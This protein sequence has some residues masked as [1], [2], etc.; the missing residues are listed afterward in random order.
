MSVLAKAAQVI[1]VLNR[2]LGP[3]R[4]GVIA[5]EVG[6]PKSSAHRLLAEMASLGMVRKLEDGNYTA[7]YRLVQW[8]H[9]ADRALGIRQAAEPVMRRL[10]E[11][12]AESVHLH[13]PEGSHRVCAAGAPGP[14]TLRPV[15][16]L[17]QVLP[18]GSGA[19]GRLLLAFADERVRAEARQQATDVDEASWPDEAELAMLRERGW[20]TTTG[21]LEEGLTA[22]SAVVK[23]RTGHALGALTI[24]GA[25]GRLND[26]RCSEVR[27]LLVAAAMD[28]A[29]SIGA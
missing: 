13:V 24:A 22:I 20:T 2:E 17:G 29:R 9:A 3:T 6:V 12:V 11:E 27:P 5:D 4:L 14:Q 23:T 15:I 10:S 16:R 18:L 26:E 7:G 25:S 19:A 28:I 8:G 21:E 1:E